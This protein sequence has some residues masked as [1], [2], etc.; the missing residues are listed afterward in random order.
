MPLGH[1]WKVVGGRPAHGR[2]APGPDVPA[3]PPVVL[4][5]GLGVATGYLLPLAERLA[6]RFRVLAPDLPG[7]GDSP[8]PARALDVPGL[9]TA[10]GA[11]VDDQDLGPA[12]LIGQSLGCQV[13]VDLAARDPA[14]LTRLV[15]LGPTADPAGRTFPQHV[16]RLAR[17]VTREP[18]PLNLLQLRD[19]LR[20][21]LHRGLATAAAMLADPV[22]GKLPR[23]RVPA[24]VVRGSR[25]PIVPQRWAH[26]IVDLLPDGRLAVVPG[27]AHL[28]H[29]THPDCTAR[30]LVPFLSDA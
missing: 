19:Y 20:S 26:Q 4:V 5:H 22:E 1:V 17:D 11:W 30:L 25:D 9:A 29:H 23:V 16:L 12:A 24:L 14:R 27:G 21:G 18:L 15:L 28:A 2:A 7:F 6:G 13:A 10:L 3:G 8:G